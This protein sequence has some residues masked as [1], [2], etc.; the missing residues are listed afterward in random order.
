MAEFAA[1]IFDSTI[2]EPG[3][4]GNQGRNWLQSNGELAFIL[5]L[6]VGCAALV[7]FKPFIIISAV[8]LLAAFAIYTTA[9]Q[10]VSSNQKFKTN[11][12]GNSGA[13]EDHS[14]SGSPDDGPSFGA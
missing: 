1:A 10:D 13:S 7:F 8:I 2:K 5:G 3:K 11:L 12:N 9:A 14:D 4:V 6:V